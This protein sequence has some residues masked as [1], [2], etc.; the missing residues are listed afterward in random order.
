MVSVNECG[1]FEVIND[2]F[3]KKKHSN[4]IHYD[5]DLISVTFKF[6]NEVKKSIVSE[7]RFGLIIVTSSIW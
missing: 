5:L 7:Q 1:D 2:Y 3:F 4:N 6:L